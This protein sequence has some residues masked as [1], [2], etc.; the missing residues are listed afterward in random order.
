M[1]WLG[2]LLIAT[3]I[4]VQSV[5]LLQPIQLFSRLNTILP[6]TL[7]SYEFDL[8]CEI[9]DGDLVIDVNQPN[10]DDVVGDAFIYISEG[11][12]SGPY[13]PFPDPG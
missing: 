5:P 11:P 9:Y 13:E 10:F 2:L 4:F 3:T 6:A 12:A 8:T 7:H 1:N